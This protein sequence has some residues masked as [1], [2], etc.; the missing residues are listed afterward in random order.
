M[1][2]S[3]HP[4]TRTTDVTETVST[5]LN[6]PIRL[7]QGCSDEDVISALMAPFP[8]DGHVPVP[9][10][11][12][13][14]YAHL[15]GSDVFVNSDDTS[16]CVEPKLEKSLVGAVTAHLLPAA[17]PLAQASE[18]SFHSLLDDAINYPICTVFDANT[19]SVQFRRNQTLK[20][21]AASSSGFGAD[22]RPDTMFTIGGLA[23]FFGEEKSEVAAEG[24]AERDIMAKCIWS[25]FTKGTREFDICYT[26]YGRL[27]QFHIMRPPSAGGS[28]VRLVKIGATLHLD[29]A[30]DCVCCLRMAINAVRINLWQYDEQRP[31]NVPD[32]AQFGRIVRSH[33]VIDSMNDFFV[34]TIYVIKAGPQDLSRPG[35]DEARVHKLHQIVC[36][37]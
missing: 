12:Y 35:Y 4:A 28:V 21:L 2:S 24:A 6:T 36:D 8:M 10:S 7:D 30:L 1:L 18:D 23:F 17:R 22:K 37:I 20:G 5:A 33:C 16:T 32:L 27:V 29:T 31:H 14:S 25:S 11:I 19:R 3:W 26:S 15:G 13:D 9:A 34:K